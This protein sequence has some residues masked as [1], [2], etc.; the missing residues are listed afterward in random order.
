MCGN[1]HQNMY[2][3]INDSRVCGECLKNYMPYKKCEDR[4]Y[5]INARGSL[6]S[7]CKVFKGNEPLLWDEVHIIHK[8]CA[9][10]SNCNI[11][12]KLDK[13]K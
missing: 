11:C 2:K 1:S 5:Q 9:K 13:K 4:I 3:K 7:C 6:A 10:K 12:R 8:C